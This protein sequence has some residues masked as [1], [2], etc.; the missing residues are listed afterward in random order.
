MGQEIPENLDTPELDK[1]LQAELAKEFP[2]AK[3]VLQITRT[4]QNREKDCAE[5]VPPEFQAVFDQFERRGKRRAP[6]RNWVRP[7]AALMAAAIAVFLTLRMIPM[8]AQAGNWW[9][10]ITKW[11]GEMF[12]FISHKNVS[13]QRPEYEFRTDNP[14]LQEL[15]DTVAELGVTD[16][17][18]P[19]WLPDGYV[20]E[21][22]KLTSLETRAGVYARFSLKDRYITFTADVYSEEEGCGYHIDEGNTVKYEN[23]GVIYYIMQNK[24]KY[25]AVWTRKNVECSLTID[26]T[27]ELMRELLASIYIVRR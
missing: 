16:P 8:E 24:G 5:G 2:N 9:D 17:V 21:E 6:R 3:L 26:G 15:Y 1:R 27:E 13:E 10:R 18:V 19:M 25:D 23:A 11:S 20:L 4:L 22:I 7:V 14:G 12:E